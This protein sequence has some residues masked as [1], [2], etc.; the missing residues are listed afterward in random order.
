MKTRDNNQPPIKSIF[1]LNVI[2][3][4]MYQYFI[5]TEKS[6]IIDEKEIQQSGYKKGKNMYINTHLY[7][8]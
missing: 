2:N 4:Y 8:N 5:F 7:I 1:V 3:V 6:P